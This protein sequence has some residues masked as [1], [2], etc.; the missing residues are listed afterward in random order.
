MV[1]WVCDPLFESLCN[2]HGWEFEVIKGFP[3]SRIDWKASQDKQSAI[4]NVINQEMALDYGLLMAKP[5]AVFFMPTVNIA[6]GRPVT[7][8][9]GMHRC[10]AMDLED[11]RE[12]DTYAV[13]LTDD[14]DLDY[15]MRLVNTLQSRRGIK[16][17][18]ILP[19]IMLMI[20][21]HGMKPTDLSKHFGV[22]YAKIITYMKQEENIERAARLGFNTSTLPRNAFSSVKKIGD[23]DA[24]WKV[25]LMAL[26]KTN[27]TEKDKAE[28]AARARN[29]TSEAAMIATI[30]QWVEDH[31]S[32]DTGPGTG[33]KRSPTRTKNRTV[34]LNLL[35]RLRR[36]L[37]AYPGSLQQQLYAT[38]LV[39]IVGDYQVIDKVTT[40]IIAEIRDGVLE[41]AKPVKQT[42]PKGG[43]PATHKHTKPEGRKNEKHRQTVG[44]G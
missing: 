42:A 8:P 6:K 2:E 36:H 38:D 13:H 3:R 10:A 40:T 16:H 14:R 33:P 37:E 22:P 19:N 35:T 17:E 27:P 41:P 18:M 4:G 29:C 24:V 12:F 9:N 39:R 30:N 7:V 25:W 32:S 26:E 1:T 23:Y 34:L 43:K 11:I 44:A 15:L 20:N 31:V 28:L 5:N 21:K